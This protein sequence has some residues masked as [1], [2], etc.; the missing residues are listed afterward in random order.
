MTIPN[1]LRGQLTDLFEYGRDYMIGDLVQV[2]VKSR[3]ADLKGTYGATVSKINKKTIEVAVQDVFNIRS[4]L[5]KVN[6]DSE[7]LPYGLYCED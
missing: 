2:V 6:R 3:D 5:V 7:L 4:F 1:N